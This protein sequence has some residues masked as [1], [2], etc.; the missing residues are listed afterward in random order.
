MSHITFEKYWKLI[1]HFGYQGFEQY[2][3]NIDTLIVST[4]GIFKTWSQVQSIT[5]PLVVRTRWECKFVYCMSTGTNLNCINLSKEWVQ[6]NVKKLSKRSAHTFPWVWVHCVVF[7]WQVIQRGTIYFSINSLL[8][9]ICL[10]QMTLHGI[11]NWNSTV[12]FEF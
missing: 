2:E 5:V 1:L 6:A 3:T 4:I 10:Y 8:I 11:K 12:V 9:V 7:Y